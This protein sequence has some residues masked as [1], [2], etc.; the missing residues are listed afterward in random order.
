MTFLTCVRC[1]KRPTLRASKPQI[2]R[3]CAKASKTCIY[4]GGPTPEPEYPGEVRTTV[5]Q[6]CDPGPGHIDCGRYRLKISDLQYYGT[7]FE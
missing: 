1:G 2:C 3:E 6:N 7:S 4:C 5:C